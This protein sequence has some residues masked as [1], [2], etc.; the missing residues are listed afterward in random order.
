MFASWLSRSAPQEVRGSFNSLFS[1]D[2]FR[3]RQAESIRNKNPQRF[4][5]LAQ[6]LDR[7]DFCSASS[8][9]KKVFSSSLNFHGFI[10]NQFEKTRTQLLLHCALSTS[11][12]RR[13]KQEVSASLAAAKEIH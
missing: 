5:K 2:C 12:R 10:T 1:A 13:R 11:K 9:Q 3:A 6:Q 7:S 8:L 4:A